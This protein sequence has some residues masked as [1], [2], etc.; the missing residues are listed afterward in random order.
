MQFLDE[1]FWKTFPLS[2][3]LAIAEDIIFVKKKRKKKEK[4]KKMYDKTD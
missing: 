2:S 3:F 4:K 1:R